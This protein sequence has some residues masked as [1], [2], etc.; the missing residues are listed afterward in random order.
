MSQDQV[1]SSKFDGMT[2]P[3]MPPPW[4]TKK[5]HEAWQAAIMPFVE[6][7]EAFAIF[8]DGQDARVVECLDGNF[9][10]V[11]P[12]VKSKSGQNIVQVGRFLTAEHA[13]SLKV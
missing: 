3:V 5:Q 12:V 2:F 11:F 7:L 13:H 6:K 9:W 10:V 1:L 4:A 8:I